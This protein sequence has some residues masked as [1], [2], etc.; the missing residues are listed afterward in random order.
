MTTRKG[1]G[2]I[3]GIKQ[4]VC[5]RYIF[6]IHSSRL[7]RERWNLT[8]SLSDARR[9]DEIIA[10]ADSQVL[11]WI[12][13]INNCG[14]TDACAAEIRREIK[15]IKKEPNSLQNKKRIRQ[16]YKDLDEVQF[17]PDYLCLIIDREKDYRRAC[18]GFKINGITYVRLLGT[19]GGIKNSTIVFVSDR[20]AG[21]LRRRID[22]GRDLSKE[23]VAAK[24]E[25]Y[26]ALTCSASIP[27][28]MP[29]GVLVV[30]D[31]MTHFKDDVICLTDDNDGEPIMEFRANEDIELDAS[32]GFGLMMPM[33]AK[34]WSGEL[35]LDYVMS[36]CCI[37]YSFTKGMVFAFDFIDFADKVSGKYIVKDM[38]GNEVDIRQV[39]LVLTESMVKLWDSYKSC[40]D[41]LFHSS[42]NG[43][44]FAVTKSCPKE[45][46]HERATNYQF[47]QPIDLDDDDIEELIAPTMN[48]IHDVLGG[49]WVKS[50]LFAKGSGLTSKNIGFIDNDVYKAV[51]IDRRMV[52]DPYI[53]NM[54]YYLI[55]GRIDEA[56]VGVINVHG[57][58]SILSGDPYALCQSMFGMEVTGLLKAGEVYNKY[59]IDNGTRNLLCF[60]AP[61]T[62]L[63]NI[64]LVSVNGGSEQRYWYR[65]MKTCTII[66]AWDTIM[67][68]LNGCDFDSD[69]MFTTDNPVLIRKFEQQ[70]ALMCAQ[71]KAKKI[72]PKEEDF[73]KSNVASFGNDI[74]KIT[75]RITSMFEVQS[76]FAK[77]SKEYDT[78]AYRIRCGQQ[79]QQ[80]AIDKIKGI[81]SKP[82]PKEWHDWHAANKVSEEDIDFYK[83]IIADKKPYFMTYIYPTLRKQYKNFVKKAEQSAFC[84]FK[85]SVSSM[86][87]MPEA[88]LTDRQREFLRFYDK[89]MPVGVGDC[90]MN[91][92]CRRFE[93][94]FD[95][96][97]WANDCEEFDY[98]IM[99]SGNDYSQRM[100]YDIK[101]LFDEYNRRLRSYVVQSAYEKLDHD[102]FVSQMAMLRDEFVS[103]CDK[104]C[105]NSSTL[106]DILLDMCYKR[107]ST[108]KFVWAICTPQ[109]IRNLLE[110]NGMKISFPELD[111]CG[112]IYYGGNRYKLKS[113]IL[114]VDE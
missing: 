106:C 113:K 19:S 86:K 74:G 62:C 41:W 56:K 55:K 24:L 101:K 83:S 95:N 12:D 68:A 10:L 42:S 14:D 3:S 103:E 112:E 91:K 70:P 31:C 73:V 100:F 94:E 66:N 61:M 44:T 69:L 89:C 63:N 21:E 5:Q 33:L 47:L 37:R 114:E 65:H 102:K 43:Y 76:H 18:K 88:D 27:V 93:T 64:R 75:N 52:N 4:Q 67:A 109:I 51:M 50:V 92:I 9:N 36:G 53:R 57:N 46:E 78:L 87:N 80:N 35:G 59:W 2:K 11:R 23:L 7:R 32:D 72:V 58:F 8:L 49:D 110:K 105:P 1:A 84:E 28:S 17:K 71:R 90:V 48:E 26:M 20:V 34:R 45:L 13:E 39:E 96:H 97:N 29:K 25:A 111:D 15:H 16:L 22:N 77:G 30:K 85:M 99:K 108:K 81:V 82:M 54:L 79:F 6:K 104:I 98:T 38:W 40:D 107:S 60:R